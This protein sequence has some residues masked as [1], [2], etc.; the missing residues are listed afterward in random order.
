MSLHVLLALFDLDEGAKRLLPPSPALFAPPLT[1]F[2][3]SA[4]TAPSGS[5]GRNATPLFS[6]RSMLVT[7]NIVEGRSTA[8]TGQDMIGRV[9]RDLSCLCITV[10]LQIMKRTNNYLRSV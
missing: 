10:H 1:L 7:N 6:P 5:H 3:T 2:M 9:S 8:L 4:V